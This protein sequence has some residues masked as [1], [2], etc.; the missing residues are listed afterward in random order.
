MKLAMLVKK[1]KP[2]HSTTKWDEFKDLLML[3]YGS[4][5]EFEQA[6]Q[7]QFLHLSQFS[8]KKEVAEVLSPRIKEL[9][10]NLDC[11]D[12][13]HDRSIV[14]ELVLTNNLNQ[15]IAKC[16][17]SKFNITYFDKIADYHAMNPTNLRPSNTFYFNAEF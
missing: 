12:K 4:L 10:N 9:I 8:T 5:Q 11:V 14:V 7:Q 6:V 15:T 17:P 3:E 16:H 2:F 13:Y 1:R